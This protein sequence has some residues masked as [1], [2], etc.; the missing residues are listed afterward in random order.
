MMVLGTIVVERV[1]DGL[2]L[3]LFLP[4]PLLLSG[5]SDGVLDVLAVLSLGGFLAAAI[6]LA[7]L[8]ARPHPTTRLIERL[9][10]LAPSRLRPVLSAWIAS[11]LTGLSLLRG[12]RAWATVTAITAISWACEAAT[13][14]LVGL[15]FDFG[16]GIPWWVYFAV[17]GAA[18]LAISAPSAPGGFGPFEFFAK[19][20]L[21]VFGANAAAATAFTLVL[22]AL[23]LVP[24][25]L[26]GLF[27]LW[28]DHLSI[29]ALREQVEAAQAAD[30]AVTAER[31]LAGA[32][33]RPA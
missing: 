18:N 31:A 5:T 19:K 33:D 12:A 22:H 29:G 32:E 11:F 6:V 15:G 21:V 27:L 2:V 28:R 13:Y 9:L 1:F 7:A 8:A 23:L 10:T 16:T 30:G 3:A 14:W 17:A 26:V 4:L 24:T 20:V 25:T